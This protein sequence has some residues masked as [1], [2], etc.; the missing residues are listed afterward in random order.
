MFDKVLC[1]APCC[2]GYSERVETPPLLAPLVYCRKE[3]EAGELVA[4][5]FYT[6]Y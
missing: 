1:S 6:N 5:R 2:P 4:P 3:S